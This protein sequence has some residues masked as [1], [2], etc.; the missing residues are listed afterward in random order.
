MIITSWKNQE[1]AQ[2]V[3]RESGCHICDTKTTGQVWDSQGDLICD[4]C[5]LE[6]DAELGEGTVTHI[7][8]IMQIA[9][10]DAWRVAGIGAD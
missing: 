10:A 5:A 2:A 3:V 6:L 1:Q 9:T 8:T 7:P 4:A